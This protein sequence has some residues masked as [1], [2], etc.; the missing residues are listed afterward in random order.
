MRR[1]NT[2]VSNG[3]RP[4]FSE[5]TDAEKIKVLEQKLR[6]LKREKDPEK[7]R[8]GVA[9][10]SDQIKDSANLKK[11]FSDFALVDAEFYRETH[12]L[13]VSKIGSQSLKETEVTP[14]GEQQVFRIDKGENTVEYRILKGSLE[15]LKEHK[16]SIPLY[17]FGRATWI[18]SLSIAYEQQTIRPTFTKGDILKKL[19]ITNLSKGG[20]VF[21]DIE[22]VFTALLN[23]TYR[24]SNNKKGKASYREYGHLW[25]K[26]TIEGEGKDAKYTIKLPEA[27]IESVLGLILGTSSAPTGQYVNHPIQFLREGR[28]L[29]SHTQ[30]GISYLIGL[31]GFKADIKVT[32]RKMLT[33][34][35]GV[36]NN[37]L[38]HPKECHELIY[39][40]LHK[41]QETG[42]LEKYKIISY[43]RKPKNCLYWTFALTL[44][45]REKV[46]SDSVVTQEE[47]ILSKRIAIWA[48]NHAYQPS[49]K[50]KDEV[51]RIALSLIKRKGYNPIKKMLESADNARIFFSK[52]QRLP[53]MNLK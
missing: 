12:P 6:E 24:I 3:Q 26:I 42:F 53:D 20:R 28:G 1:K 46:M 14:Q 22:G 23:T 25:E 52:V 10:L 37:T 30:N 9:E 49:N 18:A 51:E 21:E 41:A 8:R 38:E 17:L 13:F 50:K 40:F 32:G 45:R 15:A 27:S 34:W 19:G 11:R 29:K 47:I 7:L 44:P 2:L 31:Q 35:C 43:G 48:T 36:D 39:E 5:D 16:D 33:D 4:L